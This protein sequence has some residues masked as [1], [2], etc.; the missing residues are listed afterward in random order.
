MNSSV[1]SL[2]FVAFVLLQ[3]SANNM[4]TVSDKVLKIP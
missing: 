4:D 3:L 2:H 1:Q